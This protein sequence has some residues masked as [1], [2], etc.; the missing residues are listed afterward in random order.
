MLAWL[1]PI[2]IGFA[3]V[4]YG[5]AA[6]GKTS[7]ARRW[8]LVP[9]QI[10]EA[11]IAEKFLPA[12]YRYSV[13]VPSV[14]FVYV[15]AGERYTSGRITLATA[16][17]QS[18]RRAEVATLLEA[19]PVGASVIARVD[20]KKPTCAV[21]LERAS[22]ARRQHYLAVALGGLVL[23]GVSVFGAIFSAA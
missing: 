12:R 21:L 13:F 9:A 11:K 1:F 3:L 18:C 10:I 16:D 5:V 19:Y 23:I 6:I 8:P 20:P 17:H 14:R 2:A 7:A 22:P 15:V 4:F